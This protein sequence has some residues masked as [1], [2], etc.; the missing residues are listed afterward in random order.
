MPSL[1][2]AWAAFALIFLLALV[3]ATSSRGPGRGGT[4]YW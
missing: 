2:T 3:I 4:P 1:E